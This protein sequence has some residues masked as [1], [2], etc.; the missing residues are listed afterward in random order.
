[1]GFS[2]GARRRANGG[3]GGTERLQ[4]RPR[5]DDEGAGR[6]RRCYWA[7]TGGPVRKWSS[8]SRNERDRLA[9]GHGPPAK[10]AKIEITQRVR[11]PRAM[12]WHIVP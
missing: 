7:C 8:P 3:T 2:A 10:R 1:M 4:A 11:G 9:H 5:G 6:C 12:L